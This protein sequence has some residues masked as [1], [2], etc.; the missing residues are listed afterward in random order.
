MFILK[1]RLLVLFGIIFLF[2][3]KA[4]DSILLSKTIHLPIIKLVHSNKLNQFAICGS[5][6]SQLVKLHKNQIDNIT[7]K[8]KLPQ[9]LHFSSLL[10][11]KQNVILVGTTNNYLYCIRNSRYEQLNKLH[12]LTDSCIQSI[13]LDKD[14]K[15][16]VVTTKTARFILTSN[17]NRFLFKKIQGAI[18]TTSESPSAYK[19][20]KKYFRMPIQKAICNTVSG[21]DLS[22]RKKKYISNHDQKMIQNQLKPGDVLLKHNDNQLINIGIPGIWS[23]SAI[24][25]G[26][27]KEINEYFKNIEM[28]GKIKPFDYIKYHYPQISSKL[29]NSKHL[30]IEAIGEGVVINPLSH[31]AL[32]DCFAALR[33]KLLPQALF[34]SLLL[35]FDN[36][37]KPYDFLFD[38][39]TDDAVVCSELVYKSFKPNGEKQGVNFILGSLAGKSFISPNDIAKQFCEEQNTTNQSFD[40][41]IFYNC[42]SKLRK[43]FLQDASRFCKRTVE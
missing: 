30:I 25:I 3:V 41:V 5:D 39:E 18:A 42:D 26:G 27:E 16:I 32:V 15:M 10:W 40:L 35:A 21:I 7:E 2:R 31:C 8:S 20:F 11:I 4:Q 22:G 38:I 13:D 14:N 6:S 28:L 34:Q 29:K 12:G 36:Y 33:T 37:G 1:F 19:L 24:Y 17:Q 9:S 43:A 23:H